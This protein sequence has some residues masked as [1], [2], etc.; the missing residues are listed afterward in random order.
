MAVPIKIHDVYEKLSD[1]RKGIIYRLVLD[2]L[3]AQ[4]TEDFDNY[5]QEDIEE[6]K[7]ARNRTSNGDCLS[8]QSVE[9]MATRFGV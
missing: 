9:E 5:S 8:F 1:D 2:M 3:S 7:E 4:Q 6:I